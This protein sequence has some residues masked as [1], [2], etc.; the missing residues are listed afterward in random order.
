MVILLLPAIGYAQKVVHAELK[1]TE[2]EQR[3]DDYLKLPRDSEVESKQFLAEIVDEV[4][5]ETPFMTRVRAMSYWAGEL[6]YEE[7]FEAAYE[8]LD[9]LKET[10]ENSEV[11]DVQAELLATR[12]DLLTQEGKRG[13]AFLLVPKL[14]RLLEQTSSP[15]VRYYAHNLLASVYTQWERYDTALSNLLS[16]QQSLGEMESSLNTGRRLYLL[17]QIA[18]IQTRLEQWQSAINT[19]EE[20][21]STAIAEGFDGIAYNL[22]F[23]KYYAEVSSEKYEQ[24]I[25]SL[26][27]AYAIAEA[28]GFLS[29]QVVILNNFGDA[30]MKLGQYEKGIEHLNE[31]KELAAETGYEEMTA[32]ID[33]NLGYIAVQQGDSLGIKQMEEMLRGFRE[34][35]PESELEFVLGEMADAYGLVG[36]YQAQAELLKE[37]IDLKQEI[38]Q[39]SQAENLATLQA[40]YKSRDKAQQIELLEQQNELK[41]QQIQNNQQRQ[42]IWLLLA[43]VGLVSIALVVMLY[44]KSKRA[45]QLLNKANE[46]LA[47]QSQRDPLTGLWNRRALQEAM[48]N[49][50]QLQHSS[51]DGLILLDIDYF[52]KINDV[53]GHAIGDIVLKEIARRLQNVCRGSDR[54]IRW[55]GE[56]FLFY[57][58]DIDLEQLQQL[59]ARVLH[60]VGTDPIKVEKHTI[61][62]TAT[63]GFIQLPFAGVSEDFI[64]WERTLQ[65]ADMAL[66]T[67]KAHGRNRACGVTGLNVDYDTAKE[68]LE[69][70]FSEAIEQGWVSIVTIP[71]PK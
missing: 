61:Q 39:Q 27:K 42:L 32:T 62:M 66:Y 19:V 63:V 59:A 53:Y 4:N 24:S 16:A 20:N 10:V 9:E 38:L 69:N 54:L 28:E 21:V 8:V 11:I 23:T 51:T 52:K 67:G 14:E 1:S 70:D 15:R 25:E 22:W 3:L 64:D 37:R 17:S 30:Y 55:G 58:K 18:D 60:G 57:V 65:I 29:E 26:S 48:Q 36:N 68:A 2:L 40:V 7:N 41:E 47:D 35:L 49:R 43:V 12:V 6:G 13:E 5:A 33:F 56:E 45:N 50:S 46:Q 34:T 71:G 44:L 31:A